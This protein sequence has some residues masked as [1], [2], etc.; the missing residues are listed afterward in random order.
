MGEN[1]INYTKMNTSTLRLYAVTSSF[2]CN[3]KEQIFLI[4]LV[5]FG[6]NNVI[7][8]HLPNFISLSPACFHINLCEIK[9]VPE[10]HSIQPFFLLLLRWPVVWFIL[11]RKV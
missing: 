3:K 5:F 11:A 7:L 2:K 8:F 9:V 1:F 10:Y 6:S 4:L